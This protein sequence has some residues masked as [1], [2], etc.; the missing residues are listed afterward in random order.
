M[1]PVLVKSILVLKEH[2]RNW[3]GMTN[4]IDYHLMIHTCTIAAIQAP[5]PCPSAP[6]SYI[7]TFNKSSML[8][9]AGLLLPIL[10]VKVSVQPTG[11]L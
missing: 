1:A 7:F 3:M 5:N 10:L 11:F 4:Q 6:E 2:I 9:I 8:Q